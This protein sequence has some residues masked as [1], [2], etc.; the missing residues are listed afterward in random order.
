M[1]RGILFSLKNERI[2]DTTIGINLK[3]VMPHEISQS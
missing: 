1:Y 3:E 2:L